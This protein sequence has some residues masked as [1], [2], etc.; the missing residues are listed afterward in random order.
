MNLLELVLV[1]QMSGKI[2]VGTPLS[3]QKVN[4]IAAYQRNI[5]EATSYFIEAF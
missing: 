2:R 4:L 5:F 1:F 3:C